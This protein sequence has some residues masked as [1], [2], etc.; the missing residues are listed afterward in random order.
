MLSEMDGFDNDSQVCS[1]SFQV[2][3][4]Q[5]TR[6]FATQPPN[7]NPP[8]TCVA[9]LVAVAA[10]LANQTARAA[11]FSAPRLPPLHPSPLLDQV[12]VMAATNR[13]DILDPALVRPGRLDRI[14]YVPLPDYNGRIEILK[15]RL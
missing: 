12:V 10:R 11:P 6:H 13:R 1:A 15:V 7:Q 8:S 2:P 5:I 9:G 14:V 4:G 3:V